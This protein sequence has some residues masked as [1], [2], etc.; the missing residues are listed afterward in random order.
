VNSLLGGRQPSRQ[1]IHLVDELRP[2]PLDVDPDWDARTRATIMDGRGEV[3]ATPVHGWPARLM[4]VAA[5][6]AVLAGGV[7]VAHRWLPRDDAIAPAA[8]AESWPTPEAPYA[9]DLARIDAEF[10][11]E[12]TDQTFEAV[13]TRDFPLGK[14]PAD[15]YVFMKLGAVCPAHHLGQRR[16]D[17]GERRVPGSCDRPSRRGTDDEGFAPSWVP[18][19]LIVVP[20]SGARG[21]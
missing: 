21:A 20:L 7:V 3:A 4:I 10:P 14:A 1:T 8:P 6:V 5:A 13:G 19:P 12:P 15:S 17:R 11:T 18:R 9:R 2:E 16:D